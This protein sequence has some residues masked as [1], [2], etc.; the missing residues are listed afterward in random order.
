MTIWLI[1]DTHFGHARMLTFV[2]LDG[3]RVRPYWD[4]ADVMDEDMVERWNAVVKP[5]DHVYHLGDVTMHKPKLSIVKRLNGHKR[6]ILGNHDGF[7]IKAYQQAGFQKIF[8]SRKLDNLL[9]THI[10]VHPTSIPHW[11]AGNVHGHI[12]ER[13]AY[14]PQYLNVSVERINYTPITLEDAKKALDKLSEVC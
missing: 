13:D 10:P 12:H 9:L 2:G 7:D 1:S 4:E 14:G 5:Q 6:L 11:A 8:G 3:Q